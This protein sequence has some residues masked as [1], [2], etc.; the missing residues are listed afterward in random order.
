MNKI[1]HLKILKLWAERQTE[2]IREIQNGGFDELLLEETYKEW[3]ECEL[4]YVYDLIKGI[5]IE[6]I[7]DLLE[8][9]ENV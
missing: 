7:E 1:K 9:E 6:E 3:L 4:L 8:E 5:G 2:V